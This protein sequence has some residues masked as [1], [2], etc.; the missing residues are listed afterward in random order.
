[1][2]QLM[3]NNNYNNFVLTLVQGGF[4]QDIQVP[5]GF[6]VMKKELSWYSSITLPAP[7]TNLSH[8]L[9]VAGMILTPMQFTRS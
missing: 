3:L 7:E 9:H 4:V 1:M 8:T 6:V 2:T 5:Q